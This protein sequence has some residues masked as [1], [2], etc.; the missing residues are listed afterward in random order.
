MTTINIGNNCWFACFSA[1]NDDPKVILDQMMEMA[2][3]AK[4]NKKDMLILLSSMDIDYGHES[5]NGAS[6]I[7]AATPG[8][9]KN[10]PDIKNNV[11]CYR[12]EQMQFQLFIKQKYIAMLGTTHGPFFNELPEEDNE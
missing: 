8:F 7:I 2:A 5:S 9:A 3:Q 4:R 10:I 6:V 12:F 1:A 11:V